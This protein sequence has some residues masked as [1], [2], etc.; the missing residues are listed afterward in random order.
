MP[1]PVVGAAAASIGGSLLAGGAK[2]KASRRATVDL[3]QGNDRSRET[4]LKNNWIA[5]EARMKGLADASGRVDAATA[6]QLAGLYDA[7]G[8]IDAAT[9]AR[10]AG[11]DAAIGSE[12]AGIGRIRDLLKPYI[13]AGEQG[14][15]GMMALMGLNGAA[16]QEQAISSI[17]TGGQFTELAR[18]QEEALLANSAATGGLRGGR[19]QDALAASRSGM[20]QGLIDRQLSAFGGL[21]TLG[22]NAASNL[23]GF[24]QNSTGAISGLQAGRGE[25]LAQGQMAL[26]QNSVAAGNARAQGQLTLADLAK[27]QA[28]ANAQGYMNDGQINSDYFLNNGSIQAGGSL[29]KGEANAGM[30]GG[31][32]QGVG[33]I[34]GGMAPVGT[35]QGM[36]TQPAFGGRFGNFGFS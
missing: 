20:L 31:I 13:G 10:V 22:G 9:G 21:A 33:S 28:E 23:S 32:A 26:G 6:A 19:T 36:A 34:F 5:T 4:L 14:L 27:L 1:G 30:W 12:Q 2:K 24:E 29:A 11:I 7:R 8:N 25:A 15:S 17:K 16:A 3:Q 18:Q 35:A